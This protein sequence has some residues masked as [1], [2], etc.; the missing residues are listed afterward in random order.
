M[1]LPMIIGITICYIVSLKADPNMPSQ[2][3]QITIDA[4]TASDLEQRNKLK[5]QAEHASAQA[6]LVT[7]TVNQPVL[8]RYQP[9]ELQA[10]NSLTSSAIKKTTAICAIGA[11]AAAANPW[12]LPAYAVWRIGCA[13]VADQPLIDSAT[14]QEAQELADRGK[15]RVSEF[16]LFPALYNLTRPSGK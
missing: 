6:T 4:S 3:I 12:L 14:P 10:V 1:R 9:D 15:K 13:L 7:T 8:R 2:T 5:Q 11:M 16:V